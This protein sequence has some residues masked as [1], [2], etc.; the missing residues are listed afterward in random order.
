MTR[1]EFMQELKKLT[2]AERLAVAEATLRLV[3][4]ELQQTAQPSSQAE[5]KQRLT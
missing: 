2:S 3:R 1:A 5:M 4:E